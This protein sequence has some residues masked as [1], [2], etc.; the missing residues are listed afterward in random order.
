MKEEDKNIDDEYNSEIDLNSPMNQKYF[1]DI[2]FFTLLDN[3]EMT[4]TKIFTLKIVEMLLKKD[5]LY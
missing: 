3:Q 1:I 4:S 2:Y 5:K